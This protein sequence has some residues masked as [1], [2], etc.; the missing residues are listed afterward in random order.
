MNTKSLLI[1][2]G[3]A[4]AL[5]VYLGLFGIDDPGTQELNERSKQIFYFKGETIN[6]LEL[7]TTKTNV[8]IT[9]GKNEQWMLE[10]PVQYPADR[11]LID[12]VI[13]E[14]EFAQRVAT[15]DTEAFESIEES[16]KQM[17][18]VDPRVELRFRSDDH[19]YYLAVGN[20]TAKK[21][22]FYAQIKTGAQSEVIVINQAIADLLTAEDIEWR[23]KRIFEFETPVVTAIMLK[24]VGADIELLKEAGDWVIAR[25]YS[26]PTEPMSVNSYISGMLSARVESFAQQ[27]AVKL[28]EYGLNA[29][30]VTL[31]IMSGET[32]ET[33]N[34]GKQVPN[35]ENLYYAQTT[36]RNAVFIVTG[37]FVSQVRGLL[38]RVRDKRIITQPLNEITAIDIDQS[39]AKWKLQ[40][41]GDGWEFASDGK[42]LERELFNQF[43]A[44]LLAV[45]G[46]EFLEK[47]DEN[48][49]AYGLNQPEI[50][51]TLSSKDPVEGETEKQYVVRLST[52]QDGCRYVDSDFVD[53]LVKVP[54]DLVPEFPISRELWLA[55]RLPLPDAK[56]WKSITWQVPHSELSIRRD[57]NGNWPA[58]W[59]K[60]KLDID[61][62][63]RQIQLLSSLKITERVLLDDETEPIRKS[64]LG[65]IIETENDAYRLSFDIPKDRKVRLKLNNEEAGYV[66][67][68]AD[69]QLLAVFPLDQTA[70]SKVD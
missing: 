27:E 8:L 45:K 37:E 32:S 48:R 70:T 15:L 10:K 30:A 43:Y 52:E 38:T 5:A 12:R 23:S 46:T 56:T 59:E 60:R 69:Y 20:E 31:E 41:G 9:R 61:F 47:S 44:A 29:P 65:L 7:T 18:L 1:L 63:E 14:L 51:L 25:P 17:A 34:I 55:R 3:I 50:T 24:N 57:E 49:A 67:N 35:E 4:S 58:T 19:A 13:S 36:E 16:M 64:E 21:G 22:H 53:F 40:Q 2:V 39:K 62:L 26:G 54:V 66:I 68:E 6:R 42:P 11:S 33:L 28:A